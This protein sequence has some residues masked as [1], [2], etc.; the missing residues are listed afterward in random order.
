[1]KIMQWMRQ[2]WKGSSVVKRAIKMIIKGRLI[3]IQSQKC[4]IFFKNC[5]ILEHEFHNS[6]EIQNDVKE[7]SINDVTALGGS[8][9]GFCDDCTNA[10]L[11]KSVTL[12]EGV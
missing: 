7:S 3:S 11:F 9:Q 12:G 4:I 8:G 1:M 10:K 2:P 6:W 5:K